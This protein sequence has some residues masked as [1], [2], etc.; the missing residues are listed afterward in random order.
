MCQAADGIN[1]KTR[2]NPNKNEVQHVQNKMVRKGQIHTWVL[3][4]DSIY[5]T[6]F[7]GGDAKA[8]KGLEYFFMI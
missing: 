1:D 4:R 8:K 7:G 3:M 5:S 6:V 2:A